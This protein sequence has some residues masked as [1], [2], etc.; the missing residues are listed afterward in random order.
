MGEY[1]HSRSS[2]LWAEVG[3]GGGRIEDGASNGAFNLDGWSSCLRLSAGPDEHRE[4]GV[5]ARRAMRRNLIYCH[6][7][8]KAGSCW[9]FRRVPRVLYLWR[10][11]NSVP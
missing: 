11:K 4:Y 9:Q 6:A 5:E 3:R 10:A 8:L 7:A 1:N 2:A